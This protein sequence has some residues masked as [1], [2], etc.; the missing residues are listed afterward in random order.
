M[1]TICINFL[2]SRVTSGVI[3]E[4]CASA[5]EVPV[6]DSPQ[7]SYEQENDANGVA[8]TAGFWECGTA[9]SSVANVLN[10]EVSTDDHGNDVSVDA[11]SVRNQYRRSGDHEENERSGQLQIT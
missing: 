2:R 8:D 5:L 9:A 3:C 1:E 11:S 7:G 6:E 4:A 10:Q